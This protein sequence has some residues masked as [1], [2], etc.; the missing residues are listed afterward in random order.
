MCTEAM[1]DMQMLKE[2]QEKA[3][4]LPTP[5]LLPAMLKLLRLEV[6]VSVVI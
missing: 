6:H 3:I 2:T 4:L 1:G 5:V